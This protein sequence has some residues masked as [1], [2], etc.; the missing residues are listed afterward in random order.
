[1]YGIEKGMLFLFEEAD[2][3]VFQIWFL[4]LACALAFKPDIRQNVVKTG[5]KKPG[6]GHRYGKYGVSEAGSQS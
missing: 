5:I 2:R 3:N 1:V 6:S 4:S